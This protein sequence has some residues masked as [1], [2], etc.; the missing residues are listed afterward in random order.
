M[1]YLLEDFKVNY[2]SNNTGALNPKELIVNKYPKLLKKISELITVTKKYYNFIIYRN[3][4][5]GTNVL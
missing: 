2:K 1:F 5:I 3:F 4:N